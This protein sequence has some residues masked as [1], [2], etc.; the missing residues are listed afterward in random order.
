M[1]TPQISL[2]RTTDD[3]DI[4]FYKLGSGMPVIMLM[5]NPGSH[6]LAE[7]QVP[8]LVAFYESMAEEFA[9]IRLDYRGSGLSTREI[10]EITRETVILDIE[11]VM[12]RLG[13][14]CTSFWGW[15]Y[16]AMNALS[17][18][19]ARPHR[20]KRLVL[21]ET[22]TGEGGINRTIAEIRNRDSEAQVQIRAGLNTDWGDAANAAGMRELTKVSMDARELSLFWHGLLWSRGPEVPRSRVSAPTLFLHSINDPLFPLSEV[23]KLASHLEDSTL[24]L[25]DSRASIAPFQY[26]EAVE[27]TKA[28]LRNGFVAL[29]SPDPP[30]RR[31]AWSLTAREEEVLRLIATGQTNDEIARRLLI[32]PSTVS[33]HVSNILAKTG[34]GNRTE[35]ATLALREH[36]V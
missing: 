29:N 17:F 22:S 16:G 12:D 4:A 8:A 21:A 25:L 7:W 6:L 19:A 13:L 2:A 31:N 24:H 1:A 34:C 27:A 30:T 11:A 28:F 20:V 14:D 10:A 5:A 3:V 15:G 18:A 9:L 32:T 36:F 23:T 26:P 35:A 33:H